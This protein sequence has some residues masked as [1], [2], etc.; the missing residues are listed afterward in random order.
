MKCLDTNI[1]TIDKEADME[2]VLSYV[3]KMVERLKNIES[4][5]SDKYK[6]DELSCPSEQYFRACLDYYK[7]ILPSDDCFI[8]KLS[9]QVTKRY[10]TTVSFLIG[11][12]NVY[13]RY[14]TQ[15]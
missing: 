1:S 9:L 2:E 8:Q 5:D 3:L 12:D 14:S 6:Y 13:C 11:R 4:F 7:S 15:V 10:N